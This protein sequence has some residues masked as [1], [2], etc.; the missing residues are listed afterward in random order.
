MRREREPLAFEQRRPGGRRVHTAEFVAQDGHHGQARTAPASVSIARVSL[1]TRRELAEIF[2]P[3]QA[4]AMAGIVPDVLRV[5]GAVL[6]FG[7]RESFANRGIGLGLGMHG[8]PSDAELD[9]IDAFFASRGVVPR[10]ELTTFAEPR[11]LRRLADRGYTLFLTMDLLVRGVSDVPIV[12]GVEVHR[13]D[14]NDDAAVLEHCRAAGSGFQEAGAEVPPEHLATML[15]AARTPGTDLVAVR[16]DGR[17]VGAGSSTCSGSLAALYGTSVAAEYRRRG[18]HRALIA[19][20]VRLAAERGCSM[21]TIISAPAGPTE[22]NA[23]RVGFALGY[24]R[25]ILVRRAPGLVNFGE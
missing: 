21:A 1:P 8:D 22:R 4:E 7:G 2:E 18:I 5:A 23:L 25:Y 11:L 16:V 12:P 15:A 6:T 13:V 24:T 19:E 20:R 14:P 10:L 17:I 3:I 9:A